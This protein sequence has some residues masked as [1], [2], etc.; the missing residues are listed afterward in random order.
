MPSSLSTLSLKS[1]EQTMLQLIPTRTLVPVQ[2]PEYT[3][4]QLDAAFKRVANS[5]NWKNRINRIVVA[6]DAERDLIARAVIHYTGSVADF[7]EVGPNKY[8]VIANGYYAAI[9]S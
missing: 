6:D 1:K 4:E 2:R 7:I 8:R 3:D 5:K 9:G